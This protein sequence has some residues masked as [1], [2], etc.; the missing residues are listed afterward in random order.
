MF[1]EVGNNMDISKHEKMEI[2]SLKTLDIVHANLSH[3]S[4]LSEF[5]KSSFID[6]YRTRVPI[7]DLRTY[8]EEAFSEELI[9]HEIENSEALY[10][11][12]KNAKG[13]ICGYAKFVNSELPDCVVGD[14][15][16]E[17]QRLYV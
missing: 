7:E 3:V 6:A 4:F 11:L 9:R 12:C 13:V 15:P 10:L 2:E 5:G 17:M 14:T 1:A 16:I 8:V